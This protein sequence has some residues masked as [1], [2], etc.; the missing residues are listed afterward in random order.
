MEAG[1]PEETNIQG[2][3]KFSEENDPPGGE[4]QNSYF[5]AETGMRGG[6]TFLGEQSNFRYLYML[7]KNLATVL[8]IQYSTRTCFRDTCSTN[9]APH[10]INHAHISPTHRRVESGW[11]SAH[12]GGSSAGELDGLGRRLGGVMDIPRRSRLCCC[13]C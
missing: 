11:W 10:P 7:S 12:R 5:A 2:I 13:I 9:L 3:R 4:L 6:G 1:S 8:Q